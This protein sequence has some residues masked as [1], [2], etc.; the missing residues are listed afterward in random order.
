MSVLDI[1]DQNLSSSGR[2]ASDSNSIELEVARV[3]HRTRSLPGNGFRKI[4]LTM[5]SGYQPYDLQTFIISS[6]FHT[7]RPTSTWTAVRTWSANE[8]SIQETTPQQ[9]ISTEMAMQ[10]PFWMLNCFRRLAEK[11]RTISTWWSIVMFPQ[12][13]FAAKL[14]T[15]Y[16]MINHLEESII[17]Y[18]PSNNQ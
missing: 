14:S 9:N 7:S 6:C 3:A 11:G 13:Y 17:C 15:G 8:A 10:K 1:R 18:S 5:V 2:K 4:S 16:Q 12:I